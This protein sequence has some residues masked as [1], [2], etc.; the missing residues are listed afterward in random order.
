MTWEDLEAELAIWRA[1]G[2]D[3]PLWWRDDDAT[4]MTAELEQLMGLATD[5]A[6][7]VHLAVIPQAAQ[8]ALAAACADHPHVVPVI[9]G[10]AHENHA[11]VGQK[12]AEFGHP[13]ADAENELNDAL[14]KMRGLF[15]PALL[16]MFVP[17]WNRV[18]PSLA[19]KLLQLGYVV[20]STY[21][22]RKQ[23]DAAA[24]LRQINTHLDPIDWHASRS[25]H[26]EAGLLARLVALLQER[27]AGHTDAREPLGFL[28]HHLVHDPAIWGFTKRC[29]ATLLDGGATPINLF[30][31]KDT[32]P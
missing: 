22:P 27:R 6:L 3:L 13:R 5:L 28:T 32:L 19:P 20:L 26:D 2:L 1:E 16:E 10:W 7:P 23:R 30:E 11:P 17:P 24:G 12:K 21:L 9:H 14:S 31:M 29:L 15:G 8:S 4:R 18:D 25:L